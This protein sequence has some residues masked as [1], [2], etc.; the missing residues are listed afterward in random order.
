[1][2]K[3]GCSDMDLAEISRLRAS[4]RVI[5]EKAGFKSLTPSGL[6]RKG[7]HPQHLTIT[8]RPPQPPYP[9]RANKPIMITID[10]LVSSAIVVSPCTT[11]ETAVGRF[12]HPA[13]YFSITRPAI[14]ITYRHDN[15]TQPKI[16][17]RVKSPPPLPTHEGLRPIHTPPLQVP[18]TYEARQDI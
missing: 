1:M 5:Q 15:R 10:Q 14:V 7:C 8:P 3:G 17:E 16:A 18:Q 11:S 2:K 6:D 9:T 13:F 12:P 4:W